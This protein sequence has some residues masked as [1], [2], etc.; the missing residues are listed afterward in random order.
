MSWCGSQARDGSPVVALA[1]AGHCLEGFSAHALSSSVYAAE[2]FVPLNALS[3]LT[4]LPP[5]LTWTPPSSYW[6]SP[7]KE[8]RSLRSHGLQLSADRKLPH[9]ANSI[10]LQN[11]CQLGIWLHPVQPAALRHVGTICKQACVY[12]ICKLKDHD[13]ERARLK[14]CSSDAVFTHAGANWCCL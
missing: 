3:A 8:V 10:M 12:A 5:T 4:N 1:T 6:P 7:G 9:L 14:L 2:I 13:F 11:V